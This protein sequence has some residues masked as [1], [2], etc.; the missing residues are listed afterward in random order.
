MLTRTPTAIQWAVKLK[1]S[2]SFSKPHCF[3]YKTRTCI[4][5]V[6]TLIMALKSKMHFK[7]KGVMERSAEGKHT[8]QQERWWR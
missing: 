5:V 2:L 3:A 1:M 6:T 4:M 7:G 8:E